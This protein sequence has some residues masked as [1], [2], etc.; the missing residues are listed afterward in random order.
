MRALP[1]KGQV[2]VGAWPRPDGS[3]GYWHSIR[4][5]GSGRAGVPA[6]DW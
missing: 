4:G 5:G 1:V 6:P 3:A 2:H